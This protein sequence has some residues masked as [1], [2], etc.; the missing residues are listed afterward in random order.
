[1]IYGKNWINDCELISLRCYTR[2]CLLIKYAKNDFKNKPQFPH[3]GGFFK[4]V[5]RIQLL[6]TK[7]SEGFSFG[8]QVLDV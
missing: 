5:K 4:D 6:S 7:C 2:Q 1:M 8:L 3:Q